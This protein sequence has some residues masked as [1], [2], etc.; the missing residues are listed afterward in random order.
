MDSTTALARHTAHLTRIDTITSALRADDLNT[1]GRKGGQMKAGQDYTLG[2][3]YTKDE[4][5]LVVDTD[6]SYKILE[7]P[8]ELK[9][10]YDEAGLPWEYDP[11]RAIAPAIANTVMGAERA[12]RDQNDGK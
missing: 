3:Q 1:G 5:Y 10:L 4:K 2:R 8:D 6:G 9:R 12:T 11:R 7:S